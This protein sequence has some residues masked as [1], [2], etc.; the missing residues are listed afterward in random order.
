MIKWLG[1][2]NNYEL[3]IMNCASQ[4]N[5]GTASCRF[6]AIRFLGKWIPVPACEGMTLGND[7][8]ENS[9]DSFLQRNDASQAV[10]CCSIE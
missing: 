3:Q 5:S 8:H 4:W 9:M 7:N 2:A 6:S 1:Y 10:A